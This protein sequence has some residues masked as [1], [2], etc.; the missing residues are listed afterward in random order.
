MEREHELRF[1]DRSEDGNELG[2]ALVNMFNGRVHTNMESLTKREGT[3]ATRSKYEE[4]SMK[5]MPHL[6]MGEESVLIDIF[7]L[8]FSHE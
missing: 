7:N 6:T 8:D 4:I 5:E 2:V 3:T 1:F